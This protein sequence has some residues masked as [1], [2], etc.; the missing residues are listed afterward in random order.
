MKFQDQIETLWTYAQQILK[1]QGAHHPQLF[2]NTTDGQL[3]ICALALDAGIRPR[4]VIPLVLRQHPAKSFIF[5]TEAWGITQSK[6]LIQGAV[7]PGETVEQAADRL[8]ASLPA[9]L[10]DAPGREEL[11]MSIAVSRDYQEMRTIA[12]EKTDD[13]AIAFPRPATITHST[14]PGARLVGAFID[15]KETLALL[16]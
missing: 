15:M 3:V 5:I 13:G 7:R 14:D 4:E 12:F 1:E 6:Q 16:N 9:S 8:R 11:L 2:M 10:E